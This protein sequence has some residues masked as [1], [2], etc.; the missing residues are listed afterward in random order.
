MDKYKKIRLSNKS[1]LL[2]VPD[3]GA[4]TTTALFIFKT[5]S[6]HENKQNNGI[7]H[8][9]EHMF[10]KGS[11]KYPNTL[12][13][14][15]ALDALGCEFNAFTSKEYTGYFVKAATNK[16]NKA[17]DI[18]GD[19]MLNPRLD[20]KEIKREKGVIIEE[21]NMYQDNPM[22]HIN[23]VLENCLYGD[24]PAG[25]DTI[26]TKENINSFKRSNFVDY[27]KKQYGSESTNLILAGSLKKQDIEKGTDILKKMNQGKFQEQA[28][29]DDSQKKPK[30]KAVFKNIDQVVLALAVRTFP[31]NH[32]EEI[33][34]RLL[35]FIL[36]GAMSSRL[37]ISLRE[38]KGLAYYVKTGTE[39]YLDSGYLNTQA[40]VPTEKTQQAIKIILAE[41]RRLKN[42]PVSQKELKKA[43]DTLEGRITLE[44]EA[45]DNLANWYGHQVVSRSKIMSPSAFLNRIRK[46]TPSD[47]QATARHIFVNQ[48]LNLALI[49]RVK[50]KDFT[51]ILKL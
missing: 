17:L 43:K 6:R 5:G 1:I 3:S 7:S 8:F 46:I 45:S 36:G 18:L 42:N 29:T 9:L 19:M 15:S 51:K 38:R 11:K 37:F 16:L 24:S 31:I 32:Q 40:G 39:F 48:G 35:A 12:V 28:L 44:M 49:G 21:L 25:W 20:T 34:V 13:L 2:T 41:Y 27:L 33:A 22:M 26:G 10:F 23:D 50:S 4:K 30:I 14:A 47:L